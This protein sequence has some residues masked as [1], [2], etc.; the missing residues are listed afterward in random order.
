[1]RPFTYT[2]ASSMQMAS[3]LLEQQPESKILS[4]GTNLID[5]MKTGVERPTGLVD[6]TRLPLSDVEE[7]DGVGTITAT[8]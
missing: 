5:L 3:A 8:A 2:R 6:I 1:M 4:G 7:R